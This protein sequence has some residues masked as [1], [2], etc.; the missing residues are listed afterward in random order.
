LLLFRPRR[1]SGLSGAVLRKEI[2]VNRM[3]ISE[4]GNYIAFSLGHADFDVL[5]KNGCYWANPPLCEYPLTFQ[6]GGFSPRNLS[7]P[8]DYPK[9]FRFSL[10]LLECD[11]SKKMKPYTG[12]TVMRSR[13]VRFLNEISL[14][15]LPKWAKA[16]AE[17]LKITRGL[18][19]RQTLK[20]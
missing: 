16:F 2:M 11:A 7:S 14:S 13:K 5:E 19:F 15:R 1:L 20:T 17:L 10:D 9:R 18:Q 8:K 12:N 4:C 3:Y 6:V